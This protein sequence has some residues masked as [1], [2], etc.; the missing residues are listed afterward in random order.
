MIYEIEIPGTWL[1]VTALKGK[2]N[3]TYDIQVI[4]ERAQI[5]SKGESTNNATNL[6]WGVLVMEEFNNQEG[7]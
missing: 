3:W 1:N 4:I 5:L 2:V 7:I 6:R